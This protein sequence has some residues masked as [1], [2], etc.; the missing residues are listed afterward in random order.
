MRFTSERAFTSEVALVVGVAS[1]TG[2]VVLAPS[3]RPLDAEGSLLGHFHAAAF[4]YH[5]LRKDGVDVA[6]AVRELFQ[7][8][9]LRGLL[10]MI[11]DTRPAEGVGQSEFVRGTCWVEPIV[12]IVPGDDEHATKG[13]LT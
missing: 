4:T 7:W 2:S 3:L 8:Q 9:T 6:D 11:H 5:P 12:R 10:H 1:R 13:D